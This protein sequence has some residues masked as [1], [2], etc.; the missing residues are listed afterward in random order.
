M[1]KLLAVLFLPAVLALLFGCGAKDGL[2]S[3]VSEYKSAVYTAEAD[4]AAL[5]ASYSEREYPYAMDGI[6]ADMSGIFEV[7]AQLPDNTLTYTI[8]F[9]AG[10]KS[11]GG[12]MN[13]DGVRRTFNYSEGIPAPAEQTLTFT[14]T[15]EGEG[16]PVYTFTAQRASGGMALA[17]LLNTV[18]GNQKQALTDFS[19]DHFDGEIYVRLM[20][21]G[22]NRYYYVG[23][24]DRS[25]NCLAF[26]ADADTGEVLATKR[27]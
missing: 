10:G 23:F 1:K 25:G 18:Q 19:G 11:Y 15:A 4:G 22:E 17:D 7:C 27:P 9:E 13:Y 2:V 3:R 16:A 8:S 20:L 6:A 24:I 12:E 26:L 21:Q 14:V 5:E